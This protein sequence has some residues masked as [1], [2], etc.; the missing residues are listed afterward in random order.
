MRRS[1]AHQRRKI[2]VRALLLGSCVCS[3]LCAALVASA[4]NVRLSVIAH[5]SVGERRLG[6][7]ELYGLF[8]GTVKRWGNG[9]PA[10]PMNLPPGTPLRAEFDRTILKGE[11]DEVA[12][13]WIDQ[14]IRGKGSAPRQIPT[15]EMMARVVSMLP[16][17]VGYV[18][19]EHVPPG[20]TVLAVIQNGKVA[21]P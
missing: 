7:A 18:D 4:S 20:V 2:R 10:I 3:L 12:K 14:R 15:V 5:P 9:E 11:P 19:A 21:P 6:E 17:A 8:T 16:G 13:F 1:V